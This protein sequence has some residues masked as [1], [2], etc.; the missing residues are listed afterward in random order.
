[1]KIGIDI[2]GTTIFA[3]IFDEELQPVCGKTIDTLVGDPPAAVLERLCTLLEELLAAAG[4]KKDELEYIG[5]GCAGM[6][7]RETGTVVCSNNMN[8]N[9]VPLGR[10]LGERF[11]VP[12]Y[13]ENDAICATLGEYARGAGQGYASMIMV[14]V[15]TG[16]GGGIVIDGKLYMGSTGYA[17]AIGHMSVEQNGVHCSCG[18]QGCWENYASTTALIRMADE[19][20]DVRPDSLLAAIRGRDGALNGKNIFEAIHKEDPAA[21]EVFD[22]F[23]KC[24]SSG[25]SSLVNILNPA[26]VVLGGGVCQEGEF[27]L[28][29][30]RRSV[31]SQIYCGETTMPVIQAAKLGS[32]A[33]A[34]G[35]ACIPLYSTQK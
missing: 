23:E 6:I 28:A 27:L 9:N 34:V 8:W 22:K 12:V 33:G 7:H 15:G 13:V 14:T 1:M 32:K 2:G 26:T 25:I 5:V 20:A 35:A 24:L 29:R 31:L 3:G 4:L 16:I 11:G 30:V 19:C 18:R 21:L 17:G 10:T